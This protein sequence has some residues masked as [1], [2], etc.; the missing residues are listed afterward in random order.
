MNKV[1]K[2][3]IHLFYLHRY[4]P[5]KSVTYIPGLRSR[6]SLEPS[7]LLRELKTTVRVGMLIPM[8]NVS[9]ANRT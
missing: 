1:W 9:V 4:L 8:A 7:H 3:P 2:A 5:Q 6:V